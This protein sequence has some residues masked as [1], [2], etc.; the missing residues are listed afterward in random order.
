MI[1][2]KKIKEKGLSGD[3]VFT[4]FLSAQEIA[5]QVVKSHIVLIP[6]AIE[7]SPNSLCEAMILGVPIISSCV[8]GVQSIIT[9]DV[10][11]L[12]YQSDAPYMLEYFISELFNDIDKIKQLSIK[13]TNR[14]KITHNKD[15]IMI[16]LYEIYKKIIGSNGNY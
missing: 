15:N 8:G 5:Q 14:A 13:A 16:K 11:G 9:H 7:N 2:N 10:E 6:S 4:G 12:L 1:V 3:I